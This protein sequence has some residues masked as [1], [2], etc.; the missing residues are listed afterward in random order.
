MPRR[1]SASRRRTAN[2]SPQGE[3]AARARRPRS[4]SALA[5]AEHPDRAA[6]ARCAER[7]HDGVNG[8]ERDP[9]TEHRGEEQADDG[10]RGS[11]GDQAKDPGRGS[12]RRVSGTGA[13][14][15]RAEERRGVPSDDRDPRD[16][17]GARIDGTPRLP[18]GD[19]DAPRGDSRA[20][21]DARSPLPRD[22]EQLEAGR[23]SGGAP[24][25]KTAR[26]GRNQTA[27]AASPTRRI[28][29]MPRVARAE[30]ARGTSGSR[31]LRERRVQDGQWVSVNGRARNSAAVAITSAIGRAHPERVDSQETEACPEAGLEDVR[32]RPP[33]PLKGLDARPAG[34]GRETPAKPASAEQHTRSEGEGKL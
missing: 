11:R 25:R 20:S 27:N 26:P 16:P 7:R 8:I 19:G 3:T 18:G 34:G 12:S 28:G 33:E 24:G 29:A 6:P 17:R 15:A 31:P 4:T 30:R 2:E 32:R 5:R 10:G 13:S 14:R 22:P 1:S 21:S 23:G 9:W